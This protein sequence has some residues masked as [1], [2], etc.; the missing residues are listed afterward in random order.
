VICD[1]YITLLKPCFYKANILFLCAL[2]SWIVSPAIIK[3]FHESIRIQNSGRSKRIFSALKG[4]AIFW[5]P[6]TVL[7]NDIE[8]SFSG[9]K[10]GE[11]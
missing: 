4:T 5:C 11:A 9:D 7:I 8:S 2:H 3:Y 1:H 10:A 6:P